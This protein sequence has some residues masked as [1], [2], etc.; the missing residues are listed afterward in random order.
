MTSPN[1]KSMSEAPQTPETFLAALSPERQEALSK[2]RS[3]FRKNLPAGFEE[4]MSSGMLSYFVPHTLYPK[5]YH[6]NPKQPLPFL[7]IASTKGAVS[8]HHLGLYAHPE[9]AQWFE[10]AYAAE[11]STKLDKGKGCL[12]FKKEAAIPYNL[13]EK[14]AQKMTVAD[15]IKCYET[16][17]KKQ[18]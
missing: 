2:L 16:N 10:E 6:T 18:S 17:V 3:L 5:G 13:L 11:N 1:P 7:A 14:L 15:W 8:I 9:L 4:G 12:R